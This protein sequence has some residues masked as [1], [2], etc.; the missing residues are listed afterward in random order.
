MDL[1][2]EEVLDEPLENFESMVQ[3]CQRNKKMMD[4]MPEMKSIM[5]LLY[6]IVCWVLQLR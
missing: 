2:I 5:T 4:H 1:N 6:S 3:D